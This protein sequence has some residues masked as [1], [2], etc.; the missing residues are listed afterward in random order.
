M[1]DVGAKRSAG[2]SLHTATH[3]RTHTRTHTHCLAPAPA[4]VLSVFISGFIMM[5]IFVVLLCCRRPRTLVIRMLALVHWQSPCCG[6]LVSAVHGAGGV[7]LASKSITG[8]RAQLPRLDVNGVHKLPGRLA[9]WVVCIVPYPRVKN[10]VERHTVRVERAPVR[11]WCQRVQLVQGWPQL[12][13]RHRLAHGRPASSDRCH[14]PSHAR[15]RLG[16]GYDYR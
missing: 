3:V 2:R 1:L 6:P 12:V 4:S 8:R 16:G 14:I 7:T 13:P 9:R 11:V 10:F 15:M 5:V